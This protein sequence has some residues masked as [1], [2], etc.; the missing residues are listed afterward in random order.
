M[1]IINLVIN[2]VTI[3]ILI[4]FNSIMFDDSNHCPYIMGLSRRLMISEF[5]RILC[6]TL[7]FLSDIW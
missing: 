3:L 7:Y 2:C 4:L 5:E 6:F 1:N